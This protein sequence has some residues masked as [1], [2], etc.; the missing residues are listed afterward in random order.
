M[1][2]LKRVLLTGLITITLAAC[3][4]DAPVEILD[5]PPGAMLPGGSAV[6][7]RVHSSSGDVQVNDVPVGGAGTRT[8]TVD[9]ADGLG[10]VVA[11]VPGDPLLAVRSWHQGNFRGRSD[12]HPDTMEV[13]LGAAAL[14]G[15]PVSV[16]PL[17]SALLT[18][19]ELESF[20]NDPLTMTVTV[21]IPVTVT[22]MVDSVTSPEVNVSLWFEG[23]ALRFSALLTD[24]DVDYTAT[25]TVF[26]SSGTA[27][28]AEI[29]VDGDVD[30]ALSGVTLSN[31]VVTHTDPVI[32]DSGGLP[33]GAVGSLATLL[34]DEVPPAVADAAQNAADAVFTHLLKRLRPQ[35]GLA[36]EHPVTQDIR[37]D[38]L[39]SLA[40][41][42]VLT[43]GTRIQA[44]TPLV[45]N[46]EQDVLS[47]VDGDATRDGTAISVRVGRA[48]VNQLAFALWD[49]GNF[50]AMTFTKA[51]LEGMGMEELEFPYTKLNEATVTLLLPPLLEFD[52]TG[53]WLDLGG[54]QIDLD[55]N[56]A[57]DSSAWTAASVPVMLAQ[58]GNALRLVVDPAREVTIRDVGFD[59]M[60]TLVS[61]EKVLR[62]LRTAVPGVVDSVFGALPTIELVP[63]VMPRLDGGDGP[64]VTPTVLRVERGED[65]WLLT[66]ALR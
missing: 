49:A 60:S 10:F 50:A 36:F 33:A 53:P 64:T 54:I 47:R 37:V 66:V 22:V 6:D 1:K 65:S 58:D 45:A 30:V 4:E 46:A 41:G 16:A 52:A 40:T 59:K 35:V 13:R 55:V 8:V 20:V 51:E 24:V 7:V 2:L 14:D 9:A 48:L 11:R 44:V 3:T 39:E 57:P 38:A 31:L 56:D 26:S 15:D 17:V 32:T 61:A 23:G 63:S 25:A 18:D 29:T 19:A 5:P 12:W 21:G 62:L 34:N 42:I 43:Y 28:Y 27:R